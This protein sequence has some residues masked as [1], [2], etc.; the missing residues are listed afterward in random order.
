M[1]KC[2]SI[3]LDAQSSDDIMNLLPLIERECVAQIGL[4]FPGRRMQ[5]GY[6]GIESGLIGIRNTYFNSLRA[7]KAGQELYPSQ[8]SHHFQELELHCILTEVIGKRAPNL[9]ADILGRINSRE[10]LETLLV[11][12]ECNTSVEETAARLFTHKNTVKYRLQRVKELCGLDV[13]VFGD[14]F[15]LYLAVLAYKSCRR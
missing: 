3:L 6:G 8:Q 10:I 12:Y 7:I 11:Y 15:K 14:S 1:Q 9:F 4:I 5:I 2:T 13:R